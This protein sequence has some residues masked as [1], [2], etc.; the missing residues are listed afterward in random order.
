[1][2]GALKFKTIRMK[3]RMELI[4]RF[5]KTI[6]TIQRFLERLE[7]RFMKLRKYV[8]PSF[9]ASLIFGVVF[10]KLGI[11]ILGIIVVTTG[12]VIIYLDE[13]IGWRTSAMKLFTLGLF[14]NLILSSILGG[15]L[16]E[17]VSEKIA[18]IVI[19][20]TYLA[21][22]LLFSL[23]ADIKAAKLVN[24]AL[25]VLAAA[26]FTIGMYI[27]DIFGDKRIFINTEV[28]DLEAMK[29]IFTLFLPIIGITA[30][31]LVAVN[32]EEYWLCKYGSEYCAVD[33]A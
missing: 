2:N 1:M 4:H 8:M 6:I 28:Y 25:S 29:P 12:L 31:S 15:L 17:R 9:V 10:Y 30:I 14:Y 18:N 33:D 22:W 11:E 24:E 21:L 23:L 16:S 20:A 32:A 19:V 7:G 5:F 13:I 3:K 26:G 27:L